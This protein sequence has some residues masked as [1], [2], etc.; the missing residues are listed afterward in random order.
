[1]Y[2]CVNKCKYKLKKTECLS[3][4]EGAHALTREFSR[5]RMYTIN[6]NTPTWTGADKKFNNT[7]IYRDEKIAF[8]V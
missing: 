2:Y 5:A 4:S 3:A 8:V 1:M 6:T 7:K